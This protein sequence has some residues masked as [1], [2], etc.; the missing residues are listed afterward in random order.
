MAPDV[1]LLPWADSGEPDRGPLVRAPVL[2]LGQPGHG[3]TSGQYNAVVLRARYLRIE[4]NAE[5]ALQRESEPVRVAAQY[6]RSELWWGMH[7]AETDSAAH[8]E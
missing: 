6:H 5:P 1:S 4:E 7:E 3:A 8:G 2:E